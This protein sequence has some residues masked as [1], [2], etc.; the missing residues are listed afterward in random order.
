VYSNSKGI[1][2]VLYD[3]EKPLYKGGT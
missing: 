2:V 1:A 3:K